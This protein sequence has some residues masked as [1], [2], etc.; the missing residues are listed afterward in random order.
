MN[1]ILPE[2]LK[3]LAAECGFPLY[4]VGGACRDFLA[5]LESERRDWDICAPA[6]AEKVGRAALACGFRVDAVYSNTGTV[7]LSADG[8]EYEFTC[9]RSDEYVRGRHRPEKIYFTTD[10]SL[11]ARRR[12]FKCNA[13][14]YDVMRGEFIDPLGG[15]ADIKGRVLS[16]VAP[17]EKVFGEDGLRLM[18]LCRQAAQTGFYPDEQ[19]LCGAEKN[20][21]LISDISAERIWAELNLILH[22][23]SAYG[24]KYGQYV[25]LEL[26][27][28][29]GVLRYILPELAAGDGMPQRSDF[30]DH[31]VLEHS[32]RCVKYSD[33]SIRLAALLH[34]VG[35]PERKATS[36]KFAGHEQ[37][38]ESIVRQ[39]GARLRVPKKLTQLTARLT[40][41][42]MYD[43]DC[44]TREGKVRRFIVE[45]NDILPALLLLKQADYS[46][47]KD[48]LSTAPGVEK[49]KKIY[50]KMKNEG[51]PMSLKELAVRGDTL[52]GAGICPDEVG[53]ILNRLL[54]D[55]AQNARLNERQKLVASA[56]G[57]A[58]GARR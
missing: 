23:D 58:K 9:F 55:C 7:K 20:S 15:I 28:R 50:R 46:A 31:D 34:D 5:G 56:L 45:N 13:V 54:I 10:I 17:A 24:V 2:K 1:K 14:Y 8:E 37:S 44:R 11:D 57:Y 40:L 42:H 49:W 29:T 35:K 51:V 19:C 25:G 12:D 6:E 18:R 53:G 41:L 16:T 30:H 47:C 32:L 36:G 39:I 43:L 38:G 27:N 3:A 33:D 48:D 22:A 4:V 52:I 21:P 26:L